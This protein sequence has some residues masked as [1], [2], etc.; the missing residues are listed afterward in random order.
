MKGWSSKASWGFPKGKIGKDED[1]A[2]CA[3]REVFE[4]TGYDIS[5]LLSSNNYI[6]SHTATSTS[7]SS[8][9]SSSSSCSNQ[10]SIRLFIIP[11]VPEFTTFTPQT[12][13]EIS[14]IQWHP[15]ESLPTKY[16]QDNS[17]YNVVNFVKKLKYWI[18]TTGQEY[19]K[20]SKKNKKTTKYTSTSNNSVKT[21]SNPSSPSKSSNQQKQAQ[22]QDIFDKLRLKNDN[23]P[24]NSVL[25]R[26]NP[27]P[28]HLFEK[29]SIN[30]PTSTTTVEEHHQDKLEKMSKKQL[31]FNAV[32]KFTLGLK[33]LK[34]N[35][36][37]VSEAINKI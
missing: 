34:V 29:L 12:R 15:I 32:E 5:P 37:V 36:C 14:K 22:A 24:I 10:Q 30:Q 21:P 23:S 13:K 27:S 4:E 2:D 19:K 6:D 8:S 35:R 16:G 20:K 9:P 7:S 17:F 18:K 31:L 26:D 33:S 25:M 11:N 28:I 1:P 3:V